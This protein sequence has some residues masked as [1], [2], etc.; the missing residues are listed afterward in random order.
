MREKVTPVMED[1]AERMGAAAQDAAEVMRGQAD[2]I[3]GRVRD[4]PLTAL[5]I[6]AAIG[7][8]LGRASR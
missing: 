2:V 3:A 7:F 8:L 4:Q 1:A 6:A 5:C